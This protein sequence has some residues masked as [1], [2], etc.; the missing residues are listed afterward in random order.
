MFDLKNMPT[1]LYRLAFFYTSASFIIRA[2]LCLPNF[3]ISAVLQLIAFHY[4][5]C[6]VLVC[7]IFFLINIEYISNPT[8]VIV[9]MIVH[10]IC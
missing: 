9:I 8:E 10:T 1:S 7:S 3:I 5:R 4:L 6:L 2:M